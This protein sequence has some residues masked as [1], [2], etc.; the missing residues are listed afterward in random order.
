MKLERGTIM[1]TCRVASMVTWAVVLL[2]GQADGETIFNSLS[3]PEVGLTASSSGWSAQSFISGSSLMTL[4]SVDVRPI[5][6]I[7]TGTFLTRLYSNTPSNEP[8]ILIETL[9]GPGN[10]TSDPTHYTAS[11][12]SILIPNSPYWIVFSSTGGPYAVTGE[13]GQGGIKF[14]STIGYEYSS[15]AGASWGAF[16]Y[17][18]LMQVMGT[19]V[20]PEPGTLFLASVAIPVLLCKRRNLTRPIMC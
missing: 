8:G 1:L 13:I 2:A 14:G 6:N 11:G 16:D 5:S 15:D 7:G 9:S 17:T 12:N 19:R 18:V 3:T 4:D 10:P 20:V